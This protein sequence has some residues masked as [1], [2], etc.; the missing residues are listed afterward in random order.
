MGL[1]HRHQA[2]L[3]TSPTPNSEETNFH[4]IEQSALAISNDLAMRPLHTGGDE[5]RFDIVDGQGVTQLDSVVLWRAMA[6]RVRG[7]VGHSRSVAGGPA[8]KLRYPHRALAT[9]AHNQV[10]TT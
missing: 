3:V 2:A 6:R 10:H 5:L 9:G 1:Q 4:G 7:D 8:R